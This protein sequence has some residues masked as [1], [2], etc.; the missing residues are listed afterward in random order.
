M[1]CF[2]DALKLDSKKKQRVLRLRRFAAPL[3]MTYATRTLIPAAL[4]L[5]LFIGGW[6][7]M[8]WKNVEAGSAIEAAL[9]KWMPMGANKVLGLRPPKETVPLLGA[10]IQKQPTAELYSLRAMNEESALDFTGAETDWKK[11]ADVASDRTVGQLALAD[12][13]HRRFR[14]ADEIAV[15]TAVGKMSLPP[16]EKLRA[17]PQQSSWMAFERVLTVAQENALPPEVSEQNYRNWMARYPEQ[18][19]VHARY[20]Q[21]LLDHRKFGDAEK[22]A[23][24]YHAKFAEDET[25]PVKA[26]ALLAYRQGSVAQGLAVYETNFQPLWNQELLQSYFDLMTETHSLRKFVDKARADLG[27]NPDD[28]KA[29]AR[30]YYYYQRQGRTDAAQQTLTEYRMRK[31]QRNAKWASE[32][33]YTL[34]KLEEGLNAH[35]EAARYYYALYNA[36]GADAPEKA[37]VGLTNIL[38]TQP[39]QGVRLGSGELSMYKDIGT[40]DPGPG[41]LNGI[42]SLVL[43]STQP[44]YQF[45]QEEQRAIPYFHRAEAAELLRM[46]DAKY[47]ASTYRDGLH[48][49]LIEAYANY[50]QTDA[51][52]RDGKQFL[53]DFPKSGRREQ[54]SLLLADAYA[55][56]DRLT[57]EF[58]LYDALL[59]EL[60]RRAEGVPLGAEKDRYAPVAP[61]YQPPAQTTAIPETEDS[62]EAEEAADTD[63]ATQTTQNQRAFAVQNTKQPEVA[64][65]VRSQEYSR[66]LERYLSRL[67]S[68]NRVPDALAVLRKEIDRNLN[69]PGLYERLAAFLQQNQLGAQQEEVYQRAIQQFPDK[70]WYQKLARFYLRERRDSDFQRL[71]EQV[72]RIFSGTELEEYFRGAVG[73]SDYYTR[74][75]EYA[76]QRFPHDLYFTRNLIGEYR[77]S[78]GKREQLLRENWWMA[79]DLRNQYFELLSRSGRLDSELA[80]LKQAEPTVQQG[81]WDELAA[82]NPLATRFVSEANLWRSHFEEAAPMMGAL[83]RQFPGD[84]EI[85]HRASAVFRSLAAFEPK[86][87]DAAVAI[88]ENLYKVN[89]GDRDELARIGDILADRELFARAGPYWDRMRQVRPGEAKAYLDPA[90]VYWDYFDFDKALKLLNEG[91]AKLNDPALY[92]YEEGAIYE[93][94]RDYPA[95]VAEY[96]KGALK[97]REGGRCYG[98]LLQ[99]APRKKLRDTVDKATSSLAEGEVPT[100]E[101]VKLRMAVLDAQ[102]RPKDVAQLLANITGRTS[103]LELL[104]WVE[105][106]AREKSL[107]SVQQSALERQAAVTTDPVRRLELRYSL[108]S[109]YEGRK[110]LDAAQRN[111]EDLYRENPKILG[112]VRATVDFYWRN[113]EQQRAID[114]LLQAAKDSY[115]ELQKQFLYEA[116]RKE[117]DAGEYAQ[118]RKILEGLA[119]D[120]PYNDEYL[121]ATADT[122]AKAGDDQGLKAFYLEKI[123]L[124][125]KSTLPQDAKTRE[126]AGLR[127]GLIP[128]LTRLKDYSGAV[129]QYIE[130]VNTYPEDNAL[131]S[132]AA[133]YAQKYSREKQLVDYYAK[134]IRQSPKDYRWAM[135]LART[136]T[137]LEQYPEAIDA[138]T[139]AIQVRPDR[140]DLRTARVELLERSMR[141]DEAAAEYQRLFE[142]N[143]HD[144]RWMEKLATV[145]ARQGKAPEAVKALEAA[146]VDGRPEKPANYFEVARRLELWGMLK[147]A[148]EFAQKG[149]DSAG[150]DLLAVAEN[151]SGAQVYARILTRL[152]QQDAAYQRLWTGVVDGNSLGAQIAVAIQQV[153]KNGIASITDRQWR[154]R[155]IRIRQN[156][157]QAG[158]MAAMSEMGSAVD[159]YF[160]PEE[161]VAFNSWL[162]QKGASASTDDLISYYLSAASSA[163]LADLEA[164]WDERLMM[165]HAHK[166]GSE[167]KNRLVVLQKR[168]MRFAELGGQL[169]RYAR[170]LL[171]TENRDG[172]LF[173]AADAYR[174]GG[175][176]DHE[177]AV[178][179]TLDNLNGGLYARRYFELL[180]KKTPDRLVEIAGYGGNRE[181]LAYAALQYTVRYGDSALAQRAIAARGQQLDPV[182][183]PAYTGLAGLY[184]TDRSPAVKNAFLSALG[185]ATIGE[186]VGKPVDR[187]RQLAGNTWFYYGSR[188]G[189]WLG[190][191]RNGD[192]E[193]FLPAI[194]EQS[195]ATSSGYMTIAQYY[196]DAGN[197]DRALQDYAHVLELAPGR[198]E[199]H[200]RMAMLLWRQKKRDEAIAEW[201]RAL[202]G[203]DEQVN[204]RA[205]PGDFWQNLGDT[206]NHVGS[207]HLFAELRPEIDTVVRDY[208]RHN[209][210]YEADTILRQ[211]FVAAGDAQAAT[212]WMLELASVSPEQN[213]FLRLLVNAKW[214]P[215]S[216]KEPIYE[217]FLGRM[218]ELVQSSDGLARQYAQEDLRRRQ[219]EYVLFLIDA[220]QVDRAAT[221]L[222]SIPRSE[223]EW[224]GEV[225]AKLRIAIERKQLDSV[226]QQYREHPEGAPTG[227]VLRNVAAILQKNHREEPARRILEYVYSQEIAEHELNAA[228]MLGLAE[229]RLQDGDVAGAMQVLRR[230]SLVVGQPFENLEPAAALLTKTGHHAE[231]ASFLSELAKAKPWDEVARLHLAQEQLAAG[232]E[233]GKAQSDAMRV[234]S[235]PQAVYANRTE[236]ASV[237]KGR[238]STP[239]GSAELDALAS[240]A[241]N[242]DT[243]D[244]P[245]FYVARLQAAEKATNSQA[246]ERLLRNALDDNPKRDE[247]RIPLFTILANSAK[248][249]LAVSA[250]EPMLQSGFLQPSA[251]QYERTA[252]ESD[253]EGMSEGGPS[254]YA[255]IQAQDAYEK[256]ETAQ[257]SSIAFELGKAYRKLDALEDALRYFRAARSLENDQ[258]KQGEIDKSIAAV[259]TTIQRNAT[260]DQRV[261]IVHSEMEQA[262]T[263]RPKLVAAT[264]PPKQPAKSLKG[265]R[266]Q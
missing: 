133:L 254:S 141:F 168:R 85:G 207:R 149:V 257:R 5:A 41:F 151:R 105:T 75:N 238:G 112:V 232:I 205:V 70:S 60:G 243:A 266:A 130:I 176:E 135:V 16:S 22:L 235:D 262:N 120:A 230:L 177:M 42:L 29:A 143:Y 144:T 74:L 196:S 245:Y 218:R 43:N 13:Y 258:T 224:P 181:T 219:I 182:W 96:V 152:R 239:L 115:P 200:D 215:A 67:V 125:R 14:P 51:V 45:S 156:A 10:L 54:V 145:R 59:G 97:E 233:P 166:D 49:G 62:D 146:L 174:D 189:E 20:F 191:T 108:I 204:S 46:I 91:R 160:T 61:A 246:K 187:R 167:F 94:Q 56:T 259:Q 39:E 225:T 65:G 47:P 256:V 77:L 81:K 161:K 206:L 211:A 35:A 64:T 58:A 99:L 19:S 186:R 134:T 68:T 4:T 48:A 102:N 195:P 252:S 122:F 261:P 173:E 227:Q 242:P 193:D 89:P 231:A 53:A 95:A 234:A 82:T 140:V 107:V 123:E 21:L 113:K 244:K 34:A 40:L 171:Q 229:I 11:Y 23:A 212:T 178:L 190:V 121:A 184:D 92:S 111:L 228:N 210:T 213:G 127:R 8:E 55:R 57:E 250:L 87:T 222:E 221:V 36:N 159:R 30:V 199:I 17:I 155:E 148:R 6:A 28:L 226:L 104:E 117:T 3:R 78:P 208:V 63:D 164:R 158:M 248:E 175:D 163:N 255:P 31:E 90:T 220:G 101:A 188:Y 185:D 86:Y 198:A 139:M 38:L 15:L 194:L 132:E 240:G 251:T 83:A 71:S 76:H 169:E 183:T 98:R 103:S 241:A 260:N 79:E 2:L 142:L 106:T 88:E 50:G 202:Q 27:K 249:R 25:F 201:K 223:T 162:E 265:E 136:Q 203:L 247:A 33:L 197:L 180:L 216:A 80:A 170:T 9:Y 147:E 165:A 137:Q 72:I 126:I 116:A 114:V 263:V 131:V 209:G 237:L 128:A 217:R 69:D 18:A 119:A 138:Y 26:R 37:L 7:A 32:E 52:I 129:D 109:F 84:E 264:S 93:N 236:A 154:E 73:G 118:A 150:R 153:Q 44:E 253:M 192:P 179:A 172:V 124:F 100:F 110:D 12:F 214:I 157:A 24:Q 1:K 66:V